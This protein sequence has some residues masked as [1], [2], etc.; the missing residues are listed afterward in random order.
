[1]NMNSGISMTNHYLQ[2]NIYGHKTNYIIS[3]VAL[4]LLMTTSSIRSSFIAYGSKMVVKTVRKGY[5]QCPLCACPTPFELKKIQKHFTLYWSPCFACGEST[6]YLE[7]QQCK[8]IYNPAYFGID[9]NDDDEKEHHS[10]RAAWI[11][12]AALIAFGCYVYVHCNLSP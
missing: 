1:M 9:I 11:T 8:T 4:I 10:N 6:K 3:L 7:C 5:M 2:D 12:L